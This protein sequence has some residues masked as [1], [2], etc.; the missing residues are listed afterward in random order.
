MADSGV[1]TYFHYIS[2]SAQQ[3]AASGNKQEKYF[4]FISSP[5]GTSGTLSRRLRDSVFQ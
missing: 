4:R 2:Y 3:T 5:R 1:E